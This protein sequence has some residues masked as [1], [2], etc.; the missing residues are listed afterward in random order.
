MR[1]WK[2]KR[3]NGESMRALEEAQSSVK[4]AA[5]R[6]PEVYSVAGELRRARDVNHFAEQIYTIMRGHPPG[7]DPT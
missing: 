5:S 2:R 3:A 4:E 6:N 7:R 1:L